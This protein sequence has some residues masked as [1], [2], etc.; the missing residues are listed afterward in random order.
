M[1]I[2]AWCLYVDELLP[3]S[4]NKMGMSFTY[5][6]SYLCTFRCLFYYKHI[7]RSVLTFKR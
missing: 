3:T 1:L 4:K 2:P 7:R 5:L 6:G